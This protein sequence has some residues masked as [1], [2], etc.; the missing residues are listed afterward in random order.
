M[1]IRPSSRSAPQRRLCHSHARAQHAEQRRA[2]PRWPVPGTRGRASV[3]WLQAQHRPPKQ[4]KKGTAFVGVFGS[5]FCAR[6]PVASAKE[7]RTSQSRVTSTEGPKGTIITKKETYVVRVGCK[8][9]RRPVT[10]QKS[11]CAQKTW[12]GITSGDIRDGPKSTLQGV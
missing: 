1:Y 10:A 9:D 2:E 12:L 5:S 7:A 3:S 4:N 8:Q 6:Q 11:R